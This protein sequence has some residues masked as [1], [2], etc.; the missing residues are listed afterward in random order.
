M[1][2]T[3]QEPHTHGNGFSRTTVVRPDP[4]AREKRIEQVR[5]LWENR[6][7]LFRAFVCGALLSALIA[8]LLPKSYEATTKLM[9]PESSGGG[10]PFL[11]ALSSGNTG[12]L[13]S[14]ASSFLGVRS[15]GPVF[16]EVLESRTVADRLIDQFQLAREY[17][18]TKI[19]YTRKALEMHTKIV[20]DRKSGVITIT[21]TDRSPSQAAAIAQA[22]ITELDHL[23]LEL[24]TSSARRERIFLEERLKSVKSDLDAAATQFSEFASKNTAIDIPAQG[25]A[26]VEAAA[27][28]Q[29]QLIAAEAEASGLEKIYTVNNIRVKALN[30]RIAQLRVQ[31]QKLGGTGDSPAELKNDTALYPSIRKLPLLGVTY[32]D[33]YRRTK[34]EETVYEL[35]TQQYELAK[36]QE[37]KEI[38][39]VKVL[40]IAVAPTVKSSPHRVLL[41]AAGTLLALCATATWILFR[42][43][44][45]EID[46][47]DPG[48]V[49][50]EEM[51]DSVMVTARRVAPAA[52]ALARRAFQ[53]TEQGAEEKTGVAGIPHTTP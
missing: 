29:G 8:F 27:A 13:G 46:P 19:E 28:L 33:L 43:H 17:K 42:K 49:L 30:A 6:R 2:A 31:L 5:V 1:S 38:P 45:G 12:M 11:A 47:N 53:R 22:Y 15:N 4:R 51:A 44:W 35:L 32:A 20:E 50:A 3:I 16:V 34:I 25:K 26:M 24:S 41:T 39:S 18:T 21:V 23:V 10:A 48:R 36:V 40:D 37:A 52:T 14:L 9:P 7:T